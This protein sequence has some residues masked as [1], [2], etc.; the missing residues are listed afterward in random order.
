M[1]EVRCNV[2]YDMIRQQCVQKFLS[3]ILT[4]RHGTSRYLEEEEWCVLFLLFDECIG[5]IDLHRRRYQ[6]HHEAYDRL[7]SAAKKHDDQRSV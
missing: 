3:M 1:R 5:D 2:N 6:C 4:F 7:I